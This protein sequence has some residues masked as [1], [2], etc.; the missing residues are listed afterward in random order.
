MALYTVHPQICYVIL[1]AT[2]DISD[3]LGTYHNSTSF[4][5]R[6]ISLLSGEYLFSFKRFYLTT[7]KLNQL[8]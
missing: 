4:R 2:Y 6:E 8:Y 5:E 7:A 1:I 3:Q